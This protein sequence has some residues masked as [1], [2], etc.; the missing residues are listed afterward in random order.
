M[1]KDQVTSADPLQEKLN[2]I[3]TYQLNHSYTEE[4]YV[5]T[6]IQA[7]D[8]NGI[9]ELL[10]KRQWSYPTPVKDVFK[11]LEY[12]LVSTVG[13]VARVAIEAGI[14]PQAGFLYSDMFLAKI[15]VCTTEKELLDI[16][17]QIAVTY[18]ALV[19]QYREQASGNYLVLRSKKFI[20]DHLFDKLSLSILAEQMG[21]SAE[22]LARCFKAETGL[23]VSQ[24]VAQEK[25]KIAASLL[26]DSNRSVNE[27]ASYLQFQSTS[28]F[29]KLFKR[30]KHMTP[31]KYRKAR[32]Q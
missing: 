22:H 14:P 30:E 16:Y 17:E 21:V 32:V 15:S 23:T 2:Q 12:M 11:N 9:R 27:I 8:V 26:A 24:Y 4:K 5:F 29:I 28:Y 6:L 3:D 25:V 1:G 20:Y 13:V 7:G 19:K 18:T 10:K 31:M